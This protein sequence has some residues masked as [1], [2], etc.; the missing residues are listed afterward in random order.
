MDTGIA[1]NGST[2]TVVL[3]LFAAG[4]LCLVPRRW[5]A[6]LS[7]WAAWLVVACALLVMVKVSTGA[8]IFSHISLIPITKHPYFASNRLSAV[9]MIF[10]A[11]I[12]AIVS[13]FSL[14]F[15]QQDLL[16]RRYFVASQVLIASSIAVA[17]ATTL[18]VLSCAWIIADASFLALLFYRREL[19]GVA[20]ALRRTLTYFS[21]GAIAMVGAVLLVLNRV[22]NL[23]ITSLGAQ[24]EALTA[25]G[26]EALPV[27]ALL[28][29]AILIRSAQGPA[30][31]WMPP[32]V[33][34]PTP[35]SALLHAGVVNGGGILLLRIGVLAESSNLVTA[36]AFAIVTITAIV[37]ALAIRFRSDIKGELTISTISQMG[38]MI[39]EATI[40]ANLATLM[41]LLGH[42][43]Y[44]AS[45]FLNSPS[46]IG[47]PSGHN[48]PAKANH[49]PI[50]TK[51]IAALGALV[52]VSAAYP[53][54]S[55]HRGGLILLG[56]VAC[57]IYVAISN[58]A[59]N[60]AGQPKL[61][62]TIA[63]ATLLGSAAYGAILGGLDRWMSSSLAVVP[64]GALSPWWLIVAL[65][66]ALGL[67]RLSTIPTL[68]RHLRV[69]SIN[70]GS[71]SRHGFYHIPNTWAKVSPPK[72]S[73]RQ[74][75][76]ILMQSESS[77]EKEE[78]AA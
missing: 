57:T 55:G 13:T 46:A 53:G 71:I 45:R 43:T 2:A 62:V 69:W 34:A 20:E 31:R 21:I 4:V 44:K 3:P 16:N 12:G 22:G 61:I 19:P 70:F 1:L 75:Q 37:A 35:V 18:A 65:G 77:I 48:A 59:R 24:H 29:V 54:A 49:P 33:N 36:L 40:G 10:I 26:G 60:L 11:T 38:F 32:T 66:V 52:A 8:N 50:K 30:A 39:S 27:G 28:M 9:L 51:A 25:L 47:K 64:S 72:T 42:G 67:E 68:E 5:V 15:L 6:R 63:G 74:Y 14:R 41:H 23:N 56:F 58:A 78:A 17:T 73:R 76:R 7:V